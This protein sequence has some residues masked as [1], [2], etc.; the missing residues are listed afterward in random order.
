MKISRIEAEKF[1]CMTKTNGMS[2]RDSIKTTLDRVLTERP[3]NAA[4]IIENI[5][6]QQDKDGKLTATE[7]SSATSQFAQLQIKLFDKTIDEETAIAEQEDE[8]EIPIPNLSLLSF[9]FEQSGVG[10]GHEELYRILLSMKKLALENNISSARFWGKMFGTKQNYIIAEVE[11]R[12]GAGD[13]PINDEE[14]DLDEVAKVLENSE[15]PAEVNDLPESKWKE[16]PSIPMEEHRAGVNKN[17]YFI[18]NE[19]GEAWHRLPHATP[20]QIVASRK[21]CKLLTGCLDSSMETCPPFPGNEA[22]YL[23]SLIARISASTHI[24]PTGYYMFGEEEDG[25][26]DINDTCLKNLE[27]VGL[28]SK[29]LKDISMSSWVHHKQFILPQGRCSWYNPYMKQD[30]DEEDSDEEENTQSIK[31][32]GGPPLLSTAANDKHH[33]VAAWSSALSTNLMLKYAVFVARSN[34]WPGAYAFAKGEF[35]ENVYIGW[36]KKYSSKCFNPFCPPPAFGEYKH[37][38]NVEEMEDPDVDMENAA[39]N[40]NG[41]DEID[42]TNENENAEDM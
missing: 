23:R 21:I 7:S 8:Y 11:F 36:G 27:F 26:D 17:V 20:A 31:A 13:D 16:E 25:E 12:E 30:G 32:E 6:Q 42:S 1:V 24:S 33:H 22:N 18:C 15:A 35:Y 41:A 28:S 9:Y 39:R 37:D 19:A 4:E 2:L 10:L 14:L 29:E 5:W 34:I 3:R 38:L 40:D